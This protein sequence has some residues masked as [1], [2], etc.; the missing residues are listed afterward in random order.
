MSDVSTKV[1]I[2]K[3]TST[4]KGAATAVKSGVATA[5]DAMT[6]E[7]KQNQQDI[8]NILGEQTSLSPS[9]LS[10]QE[11][12]IV[13]FDTY[14]LPEEL[15]DQATILKNTMRA[16]FSN[17]SK[18]ITNVESGEELP[19]Q[20]NEV[21]PPCGDY[22][23]L[24][25]LASLL[26][27]A[28]KLRQQ[29]YDEGILNREQ[30]LQKVAELDPS[31]REKS[32]QGRNS[33]ISRT[34]LEHLAELQKFIDKY[35]SEQK[36]IDIGELAYKDI[37]LE[38]TDEQIEALLKQ[39]VF[40]I[41]QTHYPLKEFR[42]KDPSAPAFVKRLKQRKIDFDP[43]M[44]AYTTSG[45]K[46][47]AAIAK[48]LDS[49]KGNDELLQNTI[50]EKVKEERKRI[51]DEIA[52]K[53][54]DG[55]PFLK[56][57]HDTDDPGLVVDRLRTQ[58]KEYANGYKA[59]ET[60]K[61]SLEAT[62]KACEQ[63]KAVLEAEKTRL[64]ANVEKTIADLKTNE[65]SQEK[66]KQLEESKAAA[67]AALNARIAEF[68]KQLTDIKAEC[69]TKDAEIAR[70]TKLNDELL[71]RAE[72]AE[73]DFAA[74]QTVQRDAQTDVA[75]LQ[76]RHRAEL[77]AKDALLQTQSQR[78]DAAT[79]AS[80][81]SQTALADVQTELSAAESG[82][83]IATQEVTR[84]EAEVAE[85]QRLLT[86]AEDLAAARSTTLS[87]QE[88]QLQGLASEKAN[89]QNQIDRLDESTA[90]LGRQLEAEKEKSGG[91]GTKSKEL[92]DQLE[93]LQKELASLQTKL[94]DCDAEKARLTAENT[95]LKETTIKEGDRQIADLR[96]GLAAA[97]RRVADAESEKQRL[98]AE[99]LSLKE[100]L[101]GEQGKVE[102]LTAEG[103][104]KNEQL[105]T[106]GADL[107]KKNA[108]LS[109]LK[110]S[111]VEKDEKLTEQTKIIQNLH[112]SLSS[113]TTAQEE[114]YKKDLAKLQDDHQEEFERLK[115]DFTKTLDEGAASS[116]KQI[117]KLTEDFEEDLTEA[118]SDYTQLQKLVGDIAT[119]IETGRDIDV[120][121]APQ[122]EALT[123]IVAKLKGTTSPGFRIDSSVNHCYLVFL[124][125]HLWTM[126]FANKTEEHANII[127]SILTSTFQGGLEGKR[128]L[129]GLYADFGCSKQKAHLQPV[130]QA[131]EDEESKRC[132]CHVE[133]GD[134]CE[135][136]YGLQETTVIKNYLEYFGKILSTMVEHSTESI[137]DTIAYADTKKQ[138]KF[139][140]FLASFL[141]KMRLFRNQT[142][143]M[144]PTKENRY[145]FLDT[146]TK[147]YSEFFR[148]P[149]DSQL[150]NKYLVVLGNG[151]ITIETKIPNQ[152]ADFTRPPTANFALLF[153]AYVVLLK[154]YLNHVKETGKDLCPL[155]AILT[156]ET[157]SL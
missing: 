47:P 85:K 69:D 71:A 51:I 113:I 114:Q 41:L 16:L 62:A 154:D 4:V 156:K 18:E 107:K 78:A 93:S 3:V 129:P 35:D 106:V 9:G 45:N 81:Q 136:I 138:Q 108:E 152:R 12:A 14:Y 89:L 116:Q 67:E 17:R 59:L 52:S 74:L 109:L 147:H 126:L 61:A 137:T 145:Q 102:S 60:Q 58:L 104:K 68:T 39:F 144:K 92:E 87:Q 94:N 139:Q 72:K 30:L 34:H 70:L 79:A 112:E 151:S 38:L 141:E 99:L 26:Y 117:Q 48:V 29:L 5:T 31:G 76:E 149:R 86:E 153:F 143:S 1:A 128:P 23:K 63:A 53:F 75:A 150:Q 42:T 142:P 133:D 15:K 56:V 57:L 121:D 127:K 80:L 19:Q 91:L 123:K 10:P 64:N 66:I 21:Y 132:E 40:F 2:D 49:I 103:E 122:E 157:V 36:C 146:C 100:Q 8:I 101:K 22:E 134:R 43:Y 115:T 140:Y 135:L 25:V 55:D 20:E 13:D 24:L 125:T 27:R 130:P 73:R 95:S 84:L 97:E 83:E 44:Q 33:A 65:G 11:T 110:T 98:E 88:Q 46:I 37:G 28:K 96:G 32:I 82:I 6:P 155:P 7:G 124:T 120:K 77:A 148:S 119:S 90:E 105:S 118:T 131:I 50:L 54:P 111:S